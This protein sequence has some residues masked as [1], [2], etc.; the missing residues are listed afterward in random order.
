MGR[1]RGVYS[2]GEKKEAPSLSV[3]HGGATGASGQRAE[4]R[5]MSVDPE[6]D[7]FRHDD[8]LKSMDPKWKVAPPP[9]DFIL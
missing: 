3:I 1:Y 8:I 7:I 6:T 5:A 9:D 4:I 2:M